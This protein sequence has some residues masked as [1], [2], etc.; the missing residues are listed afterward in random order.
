MKMGR[1]KGFGETPVSAYL[2]TSAYAHIHI[3]K[4]ELI[5]EGLCYIIH[6]I[7]VSEV[8]PLGVSRG[9]VEV[10]ASDP[11]LLPLDS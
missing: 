11:L 2:H 3:N 1:R 5:S 9:V 4:I 10:D 7:S 6:Q 8:N